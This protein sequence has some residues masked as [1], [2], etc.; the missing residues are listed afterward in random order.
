MEPRISSITE[1]A[2]VLRFVL[3]GVN[4]SIANAIRRTL[5]SDIPT[6]VMRASPYDQTTIT[7]ETNTTRLN[8][9]IIRHR[10]SC[11]PIHQSVDLP[12]DKYEFVIDVSNTG[13]SVITVTTG[14]IKVIDTD[15]GKE[16]KAAISQQLFPPNPFTGDFI[17]IVRLNPRVSDQLPGEALKLKAK[18]T[19]ATAAES[20]C[21]NVV[22]C[23]A[24]GMSIDKQKQEQALANHL[25]TIR[26]EYRKQG[27]D[28]EELQ[29]MLEYAKKGWLALDGKRQTLKNSFDFEVETVGVFTNEDLVRQACAVLVGSLT[30]L[31]TT[32]G[33]TNSLADE[34]EVQPGQFVMVRL[35]NY[36]F[37]I[38]KVL[39][40]I[41]Y[42]RNWEGKEKADGLDFLA[43]VRPHPHIPEVFLRLHFVEGLDERV[44]LEERSR[45]IVLNAIE[46]AKDVLNKI[47]SQLPK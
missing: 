22:S 41:L 25:K 27:I 24:Y 2:G 6:L 4:V 28:K 26:D 21:F 11:V 10:L 45:M 14:D 37:T 33:Q 43:T 19:V 20:S 8:N 39:E 31:S 13:N 46:E 18:A 44:S 7:I 1:E 40:A 12:V 16:A 36:D 3:Q 34:F 9:E 23:A 47:R 30:E 29:E 32:L 38:A 35:A 15:T 5:L 17:P 42:I